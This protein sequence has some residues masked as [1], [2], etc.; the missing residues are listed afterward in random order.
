[1]EG[2]A[3]QYPNGTRK[4]YRN[5]QLHRDDG[6]AIE[7]PD[8]SKSWYRNGQLHRDDGPA[9]EGA[10]GVKYWYREG[11]EVCPDLTSR[12]DDVC[13]RMMERAKLMAGRDPQTSTESECEATPAFRKG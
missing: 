4:W 12:A 1:D 6:P 9:V 11:R 2:P 3:V 5:G 7:W 8:G 13:A 10:N